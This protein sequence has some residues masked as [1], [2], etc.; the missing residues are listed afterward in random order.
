ME[1]RSCAET[2]TLRPMALRDVQAA[3]SIQVIAY[4]D[5][6]LHETVRRP[7]P[8]D[9]QKIYNISLGVS[10]RMQAD[11]YERRLAAYPQ[12]CWVAEIK[13]DDSAEPVLVGYLVSYPSRLDDPPALSSHEWAVPH[14]A[15]AYFIHEVT[16][17]PRRQGLG[18][19]RLLSAKATECA[20]TSGLGPAAHYVALLSVQGSSP[21]WHRHGGYLPYDLDANR[22][23]TS[24][25][26]AS[27]SASIQADG[28]C[29]FDETTAQKL[30]TKLIQ[31]YGSGALMMLA[32]MPQHQ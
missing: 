16:V 7:P 2:P 32:A 28:P 3:W 27:A 8:P 21:F 10:T 18:L 5:P 13:E 26:S 25:P 6:S 31:S 15:D 12:G 19:G 9:H 24:L 22:L 23:H 29:L 17:D 4:S 20:R 1:E 30:K 14:P 11:H